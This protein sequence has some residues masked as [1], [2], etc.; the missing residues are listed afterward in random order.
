MSL[1]F[2]A[3]NISRTASN[4]NL[5]G[6][7]TDRDLLIKL[8]SG[9]VLEAYRTKTVFYNN[10]PP[11]IATKAI[12]SGS[13][14]Q[15]PI[16]GD[17]I[18]VSGLTT[19]DHGLNKGYH[20][21]GDF[22]RGSTVPLSETIIEVD[23]ILAV[24]MDVPHVDLDLT[25]FDVLGP[26]ATKMGRSMAIDND[27][28]IATMAIKAARTGVFPSSGANSGVIHK[29]G[30]HLIRRIADGA[31]TMAKVYID[32]TPGA[33]LFRRDVAALAEDM[34][35]RFVPEDGRFLFIPPYIRRI[36][37]NELEVFNR[38][39]NAQSAGELNTRVIGMLE[40]FK[41]VVTTSIPTTSI[42][43]FTGRATKY[44]LTVAQNTS[45]GVDPL[46]VAIALCGAGEGVAAV[47]KVEAKGI[48]TVMEDDHRRNIKFLKSQM[49]VGY[50][51]L[52]PWC[53]GMISVGNGTAGVNM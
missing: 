29:G 7:A 10:E 42:T 11:I 4:I 22:I 13:S 6:S 40:G 41:L 49:L 51:V 21:P 33:K 39:F 35:N 17:D 37:R 25:H 44:N 52:A 12:T 38:D 5:G 32:D 48:Q 20:T 27:R 45:N 53:A 2:N 36:L 9:K 31:T 19:N 14:V 50:G 8:F 46:P 16:M 28:K 24:A 47:G 43:G 30:H 23:D 1:N 15:W 18:T 3:S 34:D 26:F